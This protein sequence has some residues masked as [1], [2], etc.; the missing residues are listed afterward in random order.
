MY[1]YDRNGLLHSYFNYA[2][3]NPNIDLDTPGGYQT[4]YDALIAALES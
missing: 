2:D 1:I 3:A 4:I